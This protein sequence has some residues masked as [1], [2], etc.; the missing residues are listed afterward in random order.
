MINEKE[1]FDKAVDEVATAISYISIPLSSE[2]EYAIRNAGKDAL[3]TIENGL[4]D[5]LK[6]KDKE[7]AKE[8]TTYGS[9]IF[10]GD[11]DDVV[12][13]LCPVC[14]TIILHPEHANYCVECGQKLAWN[15]T[16]FE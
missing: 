7:Q 14:R 3:A 9:P 8:I 1:L 6:I 13:Y 15:K 10:E 11:T 2:E 12:L 4:R 16:K 5:Y